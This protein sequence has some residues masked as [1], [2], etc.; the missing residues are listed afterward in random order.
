[1]SILKWLRNV[2]P[3]R[4][5]PSVNKGASSNI[6]TVVGEVAQMYYS[7]SG[8][9]TAD[10]GQAAGV[11]VAVQLAYSNVKNALGNLEATK[12]DTSLSF[13]ST[14]FTSEVAVDFEK[15]E[16]LD[17]TTFANRLSTITSGFA[18]GQYCVD[19]TNGTLY[20]VKASTQSTL[21]AVTYKRASVVPGLTPSANGEL[22]GSTSA[23]QLPN[24]AC[25][26]VKFKATAANSGNVY[27]GGSGVT[28]PDGT[29]DT[30]SGMQLAPG[31]DSG[32]IVTPNLNLFYR[33]CDNTGDS[34]TYIVLK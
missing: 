23:L 1:M 19:Y 7:N 3:F 24:V 21:T 26:L 29:T 13:T 18:N 8:T 10:A 34:L 16:N 9:M 2:S 12:N 28:K 15:L 6:S 4:G 31:D 30:T 22:Q 32:W 11:A 20:G 17:E 33:I 25:T 14:A 5:I 27:I